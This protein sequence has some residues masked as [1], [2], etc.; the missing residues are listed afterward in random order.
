MVTIEVPDLP[1]EGNTSDG[2]V[3]GED[4]ELPSSLRKNRVSLEMREAL[5]LRSLAQQEYRKQMEEA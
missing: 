3:D 1:V 5:R 2:E 4:V